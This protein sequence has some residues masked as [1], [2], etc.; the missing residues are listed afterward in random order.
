MPFP[1][2]GHRSTMDPVDL[3]SDTVTRPGAAMRRA[4]AEAEVGDDVLGDDP[5]VRRLEARVAAL[6]GKEAALYVPSGTMGNQLALRAQSQPGQQLV[7]H[8]DSHVVRYEGGAPAALGG[9]LVSCVHTEDGSMPWPRVAEVLNPDDDVHC[10]EPAIVALENTHNRCGGRVFPPESQRATLEGARD[11]GLR[12][13][14]D[15]ARLWNAAVALGRPVSDLTAGFDT[16]SLCFSKGLGAPVGSVLVGDGDVVRRAH[17]L[18]KQW[19]GGMRQVGVLAAACL[20]A[21]DHHVERMADDH[22]RA[23]RLADELEHPELRA[24]R[25]PESNIVLFDVLG[26]QSSSDLASTF[27]TAGVL[28]SAFGP[29]RVRMVTHLDVSDADVDRALEIVSTAGRA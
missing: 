26:E 27:A 3:R 29:R 24:V 15:G 6:T 18:R 14:L 2:T 19:G 23:R 28:V 22:A 10:A 13:H 9:L 8:V 1:L 17:R 7:C 11:R 16:V 4:M 25:T 12:L 5:T 20:H 21:L